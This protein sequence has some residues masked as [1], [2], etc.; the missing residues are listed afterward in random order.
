MRHGLTGEQI[1]RFERDGF[2]LPIDVLDR[3]SADAGRRRIL[4]LLRDGVPEGRLD[5]FLYY[6]ANLV[7]R[8]VDDFVHAPALLDA[9][10]DFLGPD[11]LLWSCSFVIK[12]PRS[13]GHYTWHQDATYWGLEP[14]VGLTAW[15]ALGDVGPHNGGMRFVPGSHG[16]GQLPHANTFADDVMLPR[17]LQIVGLAGQDTAVDVVLA[18]GQVSLHTVYTAH[19][20]GPNASPGHRIGCSMV[21]I[22]THVRHGGGRESAMLVRGRDR[23][24]HF[25]L[26]PA[27]KADLDPDAIAAHGAAMAKMGTYQAEQT[28]AAG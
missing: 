27:P 7:F 5:D 3:E 18:S 13:A 11:L 12:E 28:L 15:L 23:F 20:S 17:G 6:K 1:G 19:A 10:S 4:E 14:A 22:P 25:E 2:L 24:G 26:E 16:Q 9:V 21:F 8:W